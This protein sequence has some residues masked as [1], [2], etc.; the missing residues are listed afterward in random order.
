MG[1]AVEW[2]FIVIKMLSFGQ[3]RCC[4]L[5]FTGVTVTY[6]RPAQGQADGMSQH[7]NRQPAQIS[8]VQCIPFG[9]TVIT[10]GITLFLLS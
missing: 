6:T 10:R 5:E 7:S 2:L 9:S 1:K 3:D 8:S 4:T